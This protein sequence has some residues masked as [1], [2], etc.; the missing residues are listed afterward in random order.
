MQHRSMEPS[1][2][3]KPLSVVEAQL[4][5]LQRDQV[6]SCFDLSSADL[7][8]AAGPRARYE[9]LLRSMPEYK[10]LIASEGYE[11][12]SALQVSA[13]TWKCRMRVQNTMGK[14][15]FAVDYTWELTK[16]SESTI[17]YDLGQCIQLRGERRGV[18]VGWDC[19]CRQPEEWIKSNNIDAL[20]NG[21]AQP[22]YHVLLHANASTDGTEGKFAYVA[23]ERVEC[24]DVQP[25][26]HPRFSQAFTG[27]VDEQRGAWE[28]VDAVR[29]QY[30]LG[31]EECWLVNRVFADKN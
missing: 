29:E 13:K 23:Q 7:R 19:Q 21:R 16:E 1:S 3:L 31:L 18:I 17:E 14:Q 10:P 30:P 27:K 6:N 12:L 4:D 8:A 24:I 11:L 28:P 2:D 9:H 25:I 5:A 15:R 26:N 20:P 22:F